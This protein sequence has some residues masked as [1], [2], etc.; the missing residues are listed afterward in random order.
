[1]T[2]CPPVSFPSA[3]GVPNFIAFTHDFVRLVI[4]CLGRTSLNCFWVA[5][6]QKW[7]IDKLKNLTTK[8]LKSPSLGLSVSSR[9]DGGRASPHVTASSSSG[10]HGPFSRQQPNYNAR[11]GTFADEARH[12]TVR[13]RRLDE[14][15]DHWNSLG[16]AGDVKRSPAAAE[17]VQRK[18]R[19]EE[20]EGAAVKARELMRAEDES[21]RWISPSWARGESDQSRGG[22]SYHNIF[23]ALREVL[24]SL[25]NACEIL[26]IFWLFFSRH[27]VTSSIDSE[28]YLDTVS[29]I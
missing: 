14:E 27:A 20:M 25:P 9:G 24:S 8:T 17:S 3:A 21:H 26:G 22:K 7:E 29:K 23:L 18:T 2:I 13:N 28:S 12:E 5:D 4:S 15:E 19:A 10:G 16:P 1:M 11:G 6:K